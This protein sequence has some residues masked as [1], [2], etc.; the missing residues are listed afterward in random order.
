[1]SLRGNAPEV[2]VGDGGHA[3]PQVKEK[4]HALHPVRIAL[5]VQEEVHPLLFG[6]LPG[7]GD[8]YQIFRLVYAVFKRHSDVFP[9]RLFRTLPGIYPVQGMVGKNYSPLLPVSSREG[10]VRLL[11]K[12]GL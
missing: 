1:M 2:L 7:G 12:H 11:R 6:G 4:I 3:F 10:P 8:R 9:F 5:D